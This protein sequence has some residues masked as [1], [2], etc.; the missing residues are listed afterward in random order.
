MRDGDHLVPTVGT[1]LGAVAAR[2]AAVSVHC[3][4]RFHGY[5][6]LL[7]Q[8]HDDGYGHGVTPHR[9]A[10]LILKGFEQ[11]GE[12]EPGGASLMAEQETLL[13]RKRPM[14]D[15]FVRMPVLLYRAF[16]S[17]GVVF[18]DTAGQA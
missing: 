2:R 14:L 8:V 11:D 17:T 3:G 16:S 5:I 15:E 1:N 4:V 18:N 9:E 12:G 7:S 10:S 13:V 6:H